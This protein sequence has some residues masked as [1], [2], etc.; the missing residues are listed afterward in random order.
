MKWAEVAK[1]FGPTDVYYKY[2][3]LFTQIRKQ[4]QAIILLS[5]FQSNLIIFFFFFLQDRNFTLT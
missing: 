4:I 3:N 1:F 2:V 5:F